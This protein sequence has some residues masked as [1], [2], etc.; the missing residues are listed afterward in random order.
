MSLTA[1]IFRLFL[2][3]RLIKCQNM[4]NVART[5]FNSRVEETHS[6]VNERCLST[7]IKGFAFYKIPVDEIATAKVLLHILWNSLS[8]QYMVMR[9][10]FPAWKRKLFECHWKINCFEIVPR[11]NH[12]RC[13]WCWT[14]N[15]TLPGIWEV[16]RKTTFVYESGM[17]DNEDGGNHG[18]NA[19]LTSM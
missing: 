15:V 17:D 16:F 9:F 4:T 3:R 7:A 11:F 12:V 10:N 18:W 6:N 5:H 13:S 19:L 1:H 14:Y 8:F 2:T